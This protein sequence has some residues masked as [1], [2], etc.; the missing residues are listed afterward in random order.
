MT[1]TPSLLL[2]MWRKQHFLAF[3]YFHH[4][5]EVLRVLHAVRSLRD[6]HG[7]TPLKYLVSIH[8]TDASLYDLLRFG[9]RFMFA[10]VSISRTH[11][12]CRVVS[13]VSCARACAAT[14]PL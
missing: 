1:H 5:Q 13:C 3:A 8:T 7:A 12:M 11:R 14:R 4:S 9:C 6:G 2:Q 10:S